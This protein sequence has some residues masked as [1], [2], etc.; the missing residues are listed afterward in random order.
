MTIG[1]LQ[2]L[3]LVALRA[4]AVDRTDNIAGARARPVDQGEL[5][6][7]ASRLRRFLLYE[8]IAADIYVQFSK[9]DFHNQF[10]VETMLW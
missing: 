3:I 10:R 8:F 6:S 9:I 1:V 5:G 4:Q 2:V 7:C